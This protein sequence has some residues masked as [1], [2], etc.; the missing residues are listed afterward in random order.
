[1]NCG[2]C[3][4]DIDIDDWTDDG[5]RKC[6]ECSQEFCSEQCEREHN[7]NNHQGEARR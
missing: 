3:D 6:E 2:W 1:M 7:E 4:E 5:E